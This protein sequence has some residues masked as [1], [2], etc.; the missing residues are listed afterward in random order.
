[1]YQYCGTWS[2]KSTR[3]VFEWTKIIAVR[4]RDF[5]NKST[6]PVENA[7]RQCEEIK[8]NRK[9]CLPIRDVA[10]SSGLVDQDP[11]TPLPSCDNP[12]PVEN[13]L[14]GLDGLFSDE[15]TL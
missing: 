15:V 6:S 5:E 7:I 13:A 4:L 2:I 14:S 12:S 10:F 11:Q 1:M 8:R 3:P 9:S